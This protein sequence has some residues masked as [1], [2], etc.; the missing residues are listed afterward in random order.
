MTWLTPWI[1]GIAAA[2]AVPSLLILY[3]LKLRRRDMEVSTTLLWKK[4]IQD[5][6]ANAPF[7]RLRRNLLL[8]LQ[9]LILACVLVAVAQP[10][11]R[12]QTFMTQRHIILIDHSASM[13]ATDEKD[14]KGNTQS[15][16]EQAK[17]QAVA[18]ID[19]MRDGGVLSKDE[20]D[21]AMVIS[22]DTEPTILAQF[23]RDKGS[24][25]SAVESIRPTQAPTAIA[26]TMSAALAHLP[27][28]LVEGN[29]VEGLT[30]GP[31]VT[32]HVFSDGRIPDADKAK[33]GPENRVEYHKVGT[34]EAGN[35]GITSLRAERSFD[36]PARLTIFIGLENNEK[37]PRSVDVQLVLDGTVAGIKTAQVPGAAED[38]GLSAAAEARAAARES[39]ASGVA[40]PSGDSTPLKHAL[41]RPG[42]GGVVFAMDHAEGTLAEVRLLSPS[43]GDPIEGDALTLDNRGYLA[44]PPAKKLG[45]AVVAD[46]P[47]V[48]LDAALSGLPLSKLTEFT[49]SQW[50]EQ[51]RQG[52]AGEYDVVI[53]DGWLPR[54][55]AA[56]PGLPNGRYLVLGQVP[57]AGSGL[58]VEGE[59]Q[60]AVLIDWARD[61]PA[62]HGLSLDNVL[63]A[64][65]PKVSVEPGGPKVLATSDKGPAIVEL[66]TAGTRAIVVAFNPISST[67]PFDVSYVVFMAQAVQYLGSDAGLQQV[68]REV[69]PGQVVRDRLPEGAD[70]VEL[71]QPDGSKQRITPAADGT[72]IF[73]PIPLTGKYTLSWQGTAGPTDVVEGGTAHRYYASN[74]ADSAESDIRASEELALASTV[75]QASGRTQTEGVQR[76]WPWLLLGALAIVMLEWFIYNRKVYV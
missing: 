55:D 22:Y 59:A 75:A 36:N 13:S 57:G 30:S 67:W 52:K 54:V 38:V 15:R 49:P 43:S 11:W 10:Q 42:V 51:M 39:E 2:I 23:T 65:M 27:K 50:E 58:K 46:K 53:L 3:F 62:I 70:S 14:E 26:T 44:V 32:I 69:Q 21:E 9:L 19:S 48:Y 1:G 66:Q 4:A 25:R 24:L 31:P 5:L 18:M 34:P 33:P 61:H 8:F 7:Q 12:T 20:A 45:V 16:L 17:K 73:G 41:A 35:V 74:L 71:E 37:T 63:V 56:S 76:A 47:S 64:K 40:S 72:I 60:Q 28:R 29:A 6:Q 68:G